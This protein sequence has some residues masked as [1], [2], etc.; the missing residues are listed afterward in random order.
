MVILPGSCWVLRQ[1]G[2]AGTSVSA[3]AYMDRFLW[4]IF[5]L[6]CFINFNA[7]I[8]FHH[9][10]AEICRQKRKIFLSKNVANIVDRMNNTLN[11]YSIICRVKLYAIVSDF[12]RW[13]KN[14][15]YSNSVFFRLPTVDKASFYFG[16]VV[17]NDNRELPETFLGIGRLAHV[18]VE[19]P[20]VNSFM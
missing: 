4:R 11:S 14:D 8:I 12:K 20:V 19:W 16:M 17:R 15:F 7:S 9:E 10:S 3:A 13:A 5:S 6:W 18:C 1:R 2:K